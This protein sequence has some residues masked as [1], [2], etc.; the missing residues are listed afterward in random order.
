MK[1]YFISDTHLCESRPQH[2]REFDRVCSLPDA[3]D[4]L[5]LLGD[6][7]EYWVGDDITTPVS[8]HVSH[9]LAGLR[10]RGISTYFMQGNR[11]FLVGTRFASSAKIQLLTDPTPWTLPN[12][13]RCMLTHGD[14]FCTH[15]PGYRRF[16]AITRNRLVQWAFLKL[17]KT[18]RERIADSL[19]KGSSDRQKEMDPM[20]LDVS[21]ELVRL[22]FGNWAVPMIIMGH[23]HRPAFHKEEGMARVVLGDWGDNIWYG[24][25]SPD[26]TIELFQYSIL[27]P[28]ADLAMES[29]LKDNI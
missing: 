27:E 22:A 6:I 5:V 21:D 18:R 25:G 3:G 19:R 4:K 26:K 17:S 28:S 16:R 29:I 1:H 2:L 23:T 13:T 15:D 7:F 12:G 9:T 14:M 24:L 11:D 8:N 20:L 10:Q